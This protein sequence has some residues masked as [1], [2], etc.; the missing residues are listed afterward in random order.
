MG[1]IPR[2]TVTSVLICGFLS[3]VLCAV[4]W[5]E[6]PAPKS[7][8]LVA[9][10]SGQTLWIAPVNG[11]MQVIALDDYVIP[12]KDGFWRV[13]P[14]NSFPPDVVA[15]PL[16]KGKDEATAKQGESPIRKLNQGDHAG[17]KSA[18]RKLESDS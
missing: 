14:L 10:D 3:V 9:I 13:L 1:R 18:S 15:F 12:R 5:A 11:K 8:A 17:R 2:R 7:G 6:D 4:G 16:A